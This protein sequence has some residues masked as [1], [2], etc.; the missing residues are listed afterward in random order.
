MDR[1]D[2]LVRPKDLSRGRSDVPMRFEIE[3][4]LETTTYRYGVA[5]ELQKGFK[6][7]RVLEENVS[8]AKHRKRFVGRLLSNNRQRYPLP[9]NDKLSIP[10][11]VSGPREGDLSHLTREKRHAIHTSEPAARNA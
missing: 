1:V 3:V 6:E 10:L 9:V 4:E 5:F 7:L 11:T 2:A 8:A